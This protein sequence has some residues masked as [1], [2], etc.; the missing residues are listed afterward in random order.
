MNARTLALAVVL[1]LSACAQRVEVPAVDETTLPPA[2]NQ[3][4]A[5]TPDPVVEQVVAA[6]P[7]PEAV[8]AA[9]SVVAT[10][11]LQAQ[12]AL[13]DL[14]PTAPVPEPRNHLCRRAAASLTLRWEVTSPSFYTKRLKL[15]IW[16][17]GSSGV[18]WGIG[19][20]GGHQTRSVIVDDWQ[21]HDQVDRL[22]GTAG[23]TGRAAQTVLPR[24]RDIPTPF[25][26]A[27]QVFEERSLVEYER[28]T[29]RA[30]RQGFVDLRPNACAALVSLVY[31]RGAAMTGDS[32]RE[33][34]NLRDNCVPKQ[35]YACIASELRS[36]KRLWRGTVNENGLSARRE[37]EAILAETP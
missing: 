1:L 15:P 16:P 36:M 7:L 14:T 22:S 9:S 35:D 4:P 37:A 13:E 11:L 2:V 21:T 33:M 34:R 29:E 3:L 24:F 12:A 30:F 32:R 27:S 28:R 19:Y 5:S 18:T 17:G 10:P 25:D 8:E 26:H 31:N 20:D 23:I 6:Q